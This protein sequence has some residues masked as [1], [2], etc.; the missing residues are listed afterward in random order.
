MLDPAVVV[1]PAHP[2]VPV[3]P[4]TIAETGLSPSVLVDL[5]AKAMF[6]RVRVTP[7]ELGEQAH[8]TRNVI[9][10]VLQRMRDETLVEVVGPA[11]ALD[12]YYA[13]T[14]R[15]R[16]LATEA[17]ERSRYVGPA[18]VPFREYL[19]LQGQQSVRTT[20]PTAAQIRQQLAALV[21]RPGVVDAIGAAVVST[22]TV[23]LYGPSGNG[24][25]T[26][27]SAIRGML[28]GS[29][30]VPHALDLDGQTIK[31]FDGR[32]HERLSRAAIGAEPALAEAMRSMDLRYAICR[33][34]LVVMGSE[35]TLTD[36]DLV[37]ST[38]DGTYVAPPQMKANGGVLVVDDLGRQLVRPEELLNRWIG[39][40]GTGVD[41]LVLRTGETIEVPFDVLLVFATNLDPHQLGDEAFERRIRH[42]ALI[43]SPT[44]DE[45]VEIMRR[46]A[47]AQHLEFDQ[48]TV[49]EFVDTFYVA[50]GRSP[51]GS[52][53]GDI[54][55]NLTDFA[56]FEGV[57][58]SMTPQRLRAAA[59]AFFVLDSN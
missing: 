14:V 33:R 59:E 39:P 32:V 46:E 18:P 29:I 47:V 41:H 8:L 23:L 57:P 36:L 25:S 28:P 37:F 24:K 38:I 40:M 52:H 55:R 58:P 26:I 9:E 17:F 35:L 48:R 2:P 13:L 53:A 50:E 15:G 42:K 44:R 12:Y 31:F 22:G 1:A 51:R 10:E 3:A 27:A 34:P 30:A 7:Q 56:R 45:F 49:E 20:R 21:L 6:Y 4:L 11:S 5:L 16:G 19:V 43:P 54:L